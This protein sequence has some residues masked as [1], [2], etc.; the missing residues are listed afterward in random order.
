MTRAHSFL[1]AISVALLSAASISYAEERFEVIDYCPSDWKIRS[2][3]PGLN[4]TKDAKRIVGTYTDTNKK[5]H[6]LIIENK[7]CVTFDYPDAEF[8]EL[9]AANT[10]G[11]LVGSYTSY[12]PSSGEFMNGAFLYRNGKFTALPTY[13]N[14]TPPYVNNNPNPPEDEYR[15]TRPTGITSKG[16]ILAHH[17][18]MADEYGE[19]IFK[20]GKVTLLPIPGTASDD[21][22]VYAAGINDKGVVVGFYRDYP[23]EIYGGFIL[24]KGKLRT[25]K[26]PGTDGSDTQFSGINNKGEIVGYNV[27]GRTPNYD[28]IATGFLYRDGKFKTLMVPG[29][30]ST[31]PTAIS[32]NGSV[33]VGT[34]VTAEEEVKGF[35]YY[36]H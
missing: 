14:R 4:I 9:G 30:I 22:Y 17:A 7:K 25:V 36:T 3:R 12:S 13:L 20:K 1:F 33:V 2:W 19:F 10:R 34:F 26:Y 27:T 29:S 18:F 8:T 31:T 32:D 5:A 23:R 24:K 21:G 28:D 16:E 11:E 6:G 15:Y 35:L